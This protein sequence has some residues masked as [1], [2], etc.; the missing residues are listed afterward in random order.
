MR[1]AIA[2]LCSASALIF[3]VPTR[4][5]TPS[6]LADDFERAFQPADARAKDVEQGCWLS[7]MAERDRDRGPST[8]AASSSPRSRARERGRV[9][10][11]P[12]N[13]DAD[14]VLEG[15]FRSLVVGIILCSGSPL[16]AF[17][18]TVAFP[19]SARVGCATS[20]RGRARRLARLLR[21]LVRLAC[22]F[23]IGS[24]PPWT[25]TRYLRVTPV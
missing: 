13:P 11:P 5:P 10:P 25:R 4:T 19:I 9:D 14:L 1:E 22:V 17:A 21:V 7:R 16:V 23:K 2:L 20:R 3:T 15:P 8:C 6:G 24:G 18:D 12:P